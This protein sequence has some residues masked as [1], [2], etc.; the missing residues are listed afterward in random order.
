MPTYRTYLQIRKTMGNEAGREQRGESLVRQRRGRY[1]VEQEK[2]Q[3]QTALFVR[4]QIRY[5]P[6]FQHSSGRQR[7]NQ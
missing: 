6:G 4:R 2:T 5:G 7:V 1:G 3:R